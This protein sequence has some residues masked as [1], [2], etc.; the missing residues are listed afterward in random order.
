MP[1][2]I[3]TNLRTEATSSANDVASSVSVTNSSA[4]AGFIQQVTTRVTYGGS[5]PVPVKSFNLSFTNLKFL[6]LKASGPV[7]ISL[8]DDGGGSPTDVWI[9][10]PTRLLSLLLSSA[11]T[12][13][14]KHLKVRLRPG[15]TSPSV[16][17]ADVEVLM[18]GDVAP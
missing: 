9:P 16:N 11:D 15:I 18:G 12:F 5:G 7:D 8:T 3:Q 13:P 1:Y 4:N 2:A 17:F 14:V 10:I 6:T